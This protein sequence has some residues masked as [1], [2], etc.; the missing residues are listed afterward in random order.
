VRLQGA[1]AQHPQAVVGGDGEASKVA[2][3][4]A[5]AA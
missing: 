1:A 2:A 3:A 4:A 5:G